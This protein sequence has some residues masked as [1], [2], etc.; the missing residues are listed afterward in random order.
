[1]PGQKTSI[2][3]LTITIAMIA[4]CESEN[5]VAKTIKQKQVFTS[6]WESLKQRDPAPKWFRDA[7][8]GIYFHWGVYSVPAFG[9]EWYPRMMYDKTSAEYRYHVHT[10]GEPNKFGYPDFVPMFRAEKFD[11]DQWAELFKK[12]GARFAGPVAEHHDGF[13]MWASKVNPWNTKNMGPHRDLVGELKKAVRKQ[14]LRFVTT[15]HHARNGLYEIEKD[16]KKYWTGHYEFVKKNF[17]E[18]LNDPNRAIM[19]GYMPAQ[20]FYQTWK[21]KLV[22]VIDNYQPDLMYFD[23]WLNEIPDKYKMEYLAHY[24]NE[25]G[26]AGKEVVVTYKEQDLPRQVGIEDFEKGR[27]DHLTDF[28]WLT[29]DTIST[30]SWCYTRNLGIKKPA[31]IVRTLIDIVSKNGQLMLNI[32]PMADGTIP[33]NQ[34]KVLLRIGDWLKKYGEAVYETRPFVDYGEGPTQMEKGGHFVRMKGSYSAKDIRYTRKG[35]I[36]YAILL[37]WPGKNTQ[38]T[39]TLFGKGNKA[40]N[41]KVKKV[42]M[43]GSKEKIKWHRDDAGLVVTTPSKAVDYLAVVF[44]LISAKQ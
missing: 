27:A 34:K 22:E 20:K 8:F 21:D 17:P 25:A 18:L 31:Q 15:F 12:A 29:D 11:A 32:S 37:G 23:G 2:V 1:M 44:K 28:V 9:T 19:Y 16:G 7:K 38:V 14:G 4:G 43:P 40:E 10:W 13:S 3:F 33:D 35:N 42:S 24:F 6:D 26:K 39:M 41:I 36:I 5:M 30:G